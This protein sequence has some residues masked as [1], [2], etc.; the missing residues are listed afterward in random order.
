LFYGDQGKLEENM[1]DK[2]LHGYEGAVGLDLVSTR[3]PTLNSMS[4]IANLYSQT[5]RRDMAKNI[6]LRASSGWTAA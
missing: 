3:I 6:Y 4:N 2:A 5:D 1:Y